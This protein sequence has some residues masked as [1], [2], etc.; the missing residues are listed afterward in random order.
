MIG[1]VAE[2]RFQDSSFFEIV[3]QSEICEAYFVFAM[4]AESCA[5]K[6]QQKLRYAQRICKK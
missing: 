2:L 3:N 5:T 4:N 1:A 6:V